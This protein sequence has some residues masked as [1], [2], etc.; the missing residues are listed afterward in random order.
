MANDKSKSVVFWEHLQAAIDDL[1]SRMKSALANFVTKTE[2]EAVAN[3]EPAKKEV[4]TVATFAELGSAAKSTDVIYKTLDTLKLYLWDGKQFVEVTD[5]VVDGTIYVTNIN[6]LLAMPLDKGVYPVIVGEK[7]YGETAITSVNSAYRISFIKWAK[8]VTGL[9]LKESKE[10]TDSISS[11]NPFKPSDYGYTLTETDKSN[12]DLWG[13]TYQVAKDTTVSKA[14]TLTI[15]DTTR[16]LADIS[17]FAVAERKRSTGA[18]VWVWYLYSYEGHTHTASDI[19]GLDGLGGI[20]VEETTYADLVVRRDNNELQAGSWYRIID[21]MTTTGSYDEEVRSAQHPF[22][23]LV[24][25]TSSNTLAEKAHALHSERDSEGYFA[26]NNLAAWEVWYCLDNDIRI[27]RRMWT[28]EDGDGTGVIYR[29]IDEWG[30]DCPYDHKNIQFKRY[31]T[32]GDYV[33]DVVD[34]ADWEN[35]HYI[36]ANSMDEFSNMNIIDEDDYVWV[37]TYNK[38]LNAQ[39]D[40][41]QDASMI[42]FAMEDAAGA[43]YNKAC[44]ENKMKPFYSSMVIDD[45]TYIVQVLNNIVVIAA[46]DTENDDAVKIYG[47]EFG[48]GN[49]NMTFL[50]HAYSNKFGDDCRNFV[51][52]KFYRNTF[53]NDCNYNSFGNDCLYNQFGNGCGSNQIGNYIYY[54]TVHNGV[55]Y[56]EV[57]GGENGNDLVQNAQ[58]LNGTQGENDSNKLVIEFVHNAKSTQFAGL[59]S[60]GDLRIWTPADAA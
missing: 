32:E 38:A 40:G 19:I 10:L 49:Y 12:L 17:G 44:H 37:Y 47:N 14:Y 4:I 54:L 29:L 18:I 56:V 33:S 60:G 25:A 53:G 11:D 35:T 57:T 13:C 3:K 58:I 8:Q 43:Y 48:V 23:L 28:N 55:K 50:E 27:N 31:N 52:V 22:D 34:E 5:E 46:S 39:L 21:Y 15:T 7:G 59:N 41:L 16:T 42:G 26:N 9:G 20:T 1:W 6:S 45:I 24:M 2:L 30:N 51:G 36:L